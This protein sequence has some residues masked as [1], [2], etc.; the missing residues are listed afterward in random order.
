[1]WYDGGKVQGLQDVP[2]F[3]VEITYDGYGLR[4]DLIEYDPFT[5]A[6]SVKEGTSRSYDPEEYIPT[7]STDKRP[8]YLAYVYGNNCELIPLYPWEYGLFEGNEREVLRRSAF[9]RRALQKTLGKLRKGNPLTF[10][11]YGDSI[12]AQRGG[13]WQTPNG[14]TRDTEPYYGDYPQDTKDLWPRYDHGDGAGQVHQH[15]G[16]NWVGRGF[17]FC[18]HL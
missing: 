1:M 5:G 13:T 17:R 10:A 12:T 9:N 16:W 14:T 3:D 15:L 4:Y 8:L 2:A 7:P 6:V 18:G 11:G